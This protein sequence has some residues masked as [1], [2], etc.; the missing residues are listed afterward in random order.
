MKLT[1]HQLPQADV[2]KDVVRIPE[3]HRLDVDARRIAEATV[4]KVAVS[5]GCSKLLSVRGYNS[6]EP[7]ILMDERTRND[8]GVS[9]RQEY[10][11]QLKPT[12][13]F[14]HSRW[15]WNASDPAYRVP[16]RMALLSVVLGFVGLMLGIWSFIVSW[17][18]LGH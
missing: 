10:D 17:P 9:D 7:I 3:A 8:L 15:A 13:W 18:T 4:C 5:G 14:G 11:F 2:Y 12:R 1:V 6:T 16:I